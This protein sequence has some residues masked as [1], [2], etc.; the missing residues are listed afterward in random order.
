MRVKR[1]SI[2]VGDK[3]WEALRAQAKEEE[4]SM[5][6]LIREAILELLDRRAHGVARGPQYDP[7]GDSFVTR[8]Y[9]N[10]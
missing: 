9:P 7:I 5:G 8:R 10:E 4:R 2:V 3:T 6:D 1:R